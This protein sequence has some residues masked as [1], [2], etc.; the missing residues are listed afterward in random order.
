MVAVL[1]GLSREQRRRFDERGL[2]RLEG[3]VPRRAAE[4]M[5]AGLWQELARRHHVHRKDRSTWRTERPTDFKALQKSGAFRAMATPDVR[6]VLDD[7]LGAG[8]WT[9]PLA[10]GQPLVCFPTQHRWDV[11]HQNWHL[12]LPA[13][14]QRF[15]LPVGRIFLLLAPLRPRG[16]GTLVATGSHRLVAALADRSDVELSS[17]VMRKHLKSEHRWFAEL[18][19]STRDFDR[20]ERFMA[21]PTIVNGVPVQVEEM[22]G[23][24][25]DVLVMHPAALHTLAPNVLDEPRLALAQSVYPK[26]YFA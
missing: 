13:H 20:S 23:E 17:S 12:D 21:A 25:G 1:Q 5:A 14:P 4:E 7:L 22:T 15:R 19:S 8:A 26:A 11:P 10:W 16:G 24:P 9:E 2:V 3:L 6:A 18:M